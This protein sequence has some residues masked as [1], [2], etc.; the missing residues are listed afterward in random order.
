MPL[1]RTTLTLVLLLSPHAALACG[2]MVS[3]SGQ[4][5]LLG[6]EALL[7]WDGNG[8]DL[9]VSVGFTSADPTAAWL[10]PLPAP[11]EISEADRDL[12]AEAFEITAPPQKEE[13]VPEILP[14]GEGDEIA[15]GGAPGVDVIGRDTIGGLRFV[16]LGGGK[17]A[18][19]T[20]WMRKHGF[21]FH[22]RQEPVI[23]R[24]LDQGWVIVAARVAP[25]GT[26]TAS[27]VPVRFSFSAGQP[28]YPLAMAGTGHEEQDLEVS[29]FVLSPYRPTST[30]YLE[31]VVRPDSSGDF[32]PPGR[33]LELRYSA[34]LGADASRMDA[35]PGTWLSRYEGNLRTRDLSTDLVF[36]P[37]AEQ[38]RIN[39]EELASDL[40]TQR[41]WIYVQRIAIPLAF[42]L[43]AI[44]VS[45]WLARRRRAHEAARMP[46]GIPPPPG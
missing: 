33:R 31:R 7:R 5:E 16:T 29:L 43:F 4:A 12:I 18:D 23:Q 30:T 28:V 26:T 24:Y 46:P 3:E 32:D 8:E 40:A 45:I 15:V 22:D 37:S 20:R 35:A 2:G 19:V 13:V 10:M 39:Y 38:E 36:A 34:P 9:I 17:A 11:P 27:L 1:L 21:T 14:E 6:F 42:V 25:G 41:T 44:W